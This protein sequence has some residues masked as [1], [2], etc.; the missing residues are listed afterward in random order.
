MLLL[1]L[2]LSLVR[3][4]SAEAVP[5]MVGSSVDML[6]EEKNDKG[7]RLPPSSLRLVSKVNLLL[8]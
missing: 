8:Q 1:A 3:L 5:W 7:S 4:D 6:A 2:L